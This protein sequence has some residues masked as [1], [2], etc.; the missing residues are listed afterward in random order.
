MKPL[1]RSMIGQVIVMSI[2]VDL[3]NRQYVLLHGDDLETT[4]MLQLRRMI[5]E[6]V[7]KTP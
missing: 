1:S 5:L 7:W 4:R 2:R 6:V 3:S